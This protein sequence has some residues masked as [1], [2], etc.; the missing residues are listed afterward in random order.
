MAYLVQSVS[1]SIQ[2]G[3]AASILGIVGPTRKLNE[4]NDQIT[5]LKLNMLSVILTYDI[6]QKKIN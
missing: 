3:N 4:I 6:C 2:R 5:P 1:M